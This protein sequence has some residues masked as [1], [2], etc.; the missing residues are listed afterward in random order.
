MRVSLAS[1]A[2]AI[3]TSSGASVAA[4]APPPCVT[5]EFRSSSALVSGFYRVQ[6]ET[7]ADKPVY[8]ADDPLQDDAAGHSPRR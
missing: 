7:S 5:V 4:K 8:R 6:E 3:A 1:L 2:A